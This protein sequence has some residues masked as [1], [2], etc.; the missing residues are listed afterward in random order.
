[1]NNKKNII[2]ILLCIIVFSIIIYRVISKKIENISAD[3]HNLQEDVTEIKY[4][5]VNR[6]KDK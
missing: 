6:D 4:R 1:M 3:V 2:V 5:Q